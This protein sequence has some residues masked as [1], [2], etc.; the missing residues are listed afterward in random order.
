MDKNKMLERRF[1]EGMRYLYDEEFKAEKQ[2][3]F[4][5]KEQYRDLPIKDWPDFTVRWSLE[6]ADQHYA[7]DG[8]D[9]ESFFEEYP[10]GLR[11]IE[12]VKIAELDDRLHSV[13]RQHPDEFWKIGWVGSKAE[14]I[15]HFVEN[16]ALTPPLVCIHNGNLLYIGG[17]NQRLA[18]AR[19][20]GEEAI[21]IL[22]KPSEYD[23]VIDIL[24]CRS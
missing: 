23:K 5:M 22:V 3:I 16:K 11:V 19:A 8:L 12:S 13:S 7:F 20:K 24:N 21:P 4:E 6:K 1:R 15:L 9:P 17:G 14:I 2:R 18:V 10:E